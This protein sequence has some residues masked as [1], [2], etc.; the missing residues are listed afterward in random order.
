MNRASPFLVVTMLGLWTAFSAAAQQPAPVPSKPATAA[1]KAANQKVLGALPF[2]DKQD[3]EDAQR[4]F[5]ARPETLTIR[6]A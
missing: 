5:I 6:N 2:S 4:G 1:T 3:F